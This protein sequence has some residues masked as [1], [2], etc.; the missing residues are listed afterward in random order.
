MGGAS[1]LYE[2]GIDTITDAVRWDKAF[3][4]MKCYVYEQYWQ[5]V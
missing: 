4:K 2:N 1:A 3:K 5:S